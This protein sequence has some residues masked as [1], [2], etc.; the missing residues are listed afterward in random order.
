MSNNITPI[1]LSGVPAD[2]SPDALRDARRERGFTLIEIMAVVIIMG[3]L[4]GAVGVSVLNQ[5]DTARRT[6]AKAKITQL[7]SALEFYH[8]DNA[9]Y[10]P[11]LDALITKP[12]GARNYPRGGY[13]KKRDAL[14]D[15]WNLK[16]IYLNPGSKNQYSIDLSSAGPD[17]VTGNDDDVTN[18]D[19]QAASES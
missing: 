2:L 7:E 11:T 19:S 17:G 8:M 12:P 3:L 13:L 16:F 9:K 15:P 6:T 4:M 10:P 1:P 14:L 18:W 5:L